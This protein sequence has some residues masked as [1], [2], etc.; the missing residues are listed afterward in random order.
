MAGFRRGGLAGPA[1]DLPSL[2]GARHRFPG[3]CRLRSRR[4]VGFTRES[5]D[6]ARR[7]STCVDA[8]PS[9]RSRPRLGLSPTVEDT[10]W[11]ALCCLL[12]RCGKI[13][14]VRPAPCSSGRRS[15][16]HRAHAGTRCRAIAKRCPSKG[17]ALGQLRHKAINRAELF[18]TVATLMEVEPPEVSNGLRHVPHWTAMAIYGGR[19]ATK[20]DLPA[21]VI[22]KVPS[23]NKALQ[24]DGRSLGGRH[25]HQQ[26]RGG[27]RGKG[28]RIAERGRSLDARR[29][30]R[31][32]GF[33]MKLER[34]G[35]RAAASP[36]R[37]GAALV[38]ARVHGLG[39][40]RAGAPESGLTSQPAI[41][42]R[43]AVLIAATHRADDGDEAS[44]PSPRHRLSGG[45]GGTGILLR[46][47][48]TA[49]Q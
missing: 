1:S 27:S 7:T 43:P 32:G 19:S 22:E 13:S 20:A 17:G 48:T 23:R 39:P 9:F 31:R 5:R 38:Q 28:R 49:V 47:G 33:E 4:A 8:A 12:T 15:T 6:W 34:W 26:R 41:P 24:V 10:F 44:F 21:K 2:G 45:G 18:T 46:R 36:N 11:V 14:W 37:A 35:R 29:E 3:T 42:T 25:R 30:A 16:D 40:A